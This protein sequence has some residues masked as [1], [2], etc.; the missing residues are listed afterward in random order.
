QGLSI[1][2]IPH[3]HQYNKRDAPEVLPVAKMEAALNPYRAPSFETCAT[4]GV[5][6]FEAL[7][8]ITTLVLS[9]LRR[10]GVW[11]AAP[12][13]SESEL[14]SE[15]SV[16]GRRTPT[17]VGEGSIEQSLQALAEREQFSAASNTEVGLTP[18]SPESTQVSGS[19]GDAS[20][21]PTQAVPLSEVVPAG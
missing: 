17:G 13:A 5:G 2:K 9:D 7:K 11:R 6:V 1:D 20:A 14:G 16:R 10:R 18:L 12:L 8:K 15:S 21:V 19:S 4:T 3:L